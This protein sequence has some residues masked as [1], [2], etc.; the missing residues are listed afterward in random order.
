M[1]TWECDAP[2]CGATASLVIPIGIA[3]LDDPDFP[4]LVEVKHVC[5]RHEAHFQVDPEAQ[6]KF[7][8][9]LQRR[10]GRQ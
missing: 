8:A 1:S 7:A 9:A 5:K 6:A 4:G 2:G 10:K 3:P